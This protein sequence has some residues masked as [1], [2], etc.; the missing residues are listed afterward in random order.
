VIGEHNCRAA[1][2]C[3]TPGQADRRA[4]HYAGRVGVVEY[5]DLRGRFT[6]CACQVCNSNR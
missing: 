5:K 4:H 2:L 1:E 6:R 3:N